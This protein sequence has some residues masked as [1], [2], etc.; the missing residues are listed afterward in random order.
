MQ[1]KIQNF[2]EDKK[3]L[4]VFQKLL[5]PCALDESCLSIGRVKLS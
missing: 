1:F 4:D 3:G 2:K 5:R